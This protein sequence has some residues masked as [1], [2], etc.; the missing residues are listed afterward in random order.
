MVLETTR[1]I[2]WSVVQFLIQHNKHKGTMCFE[3]N[4]TALN[5]HWRFFKQK[6]VTVFSSDSVAMNDQGS[7]L[8][9]TLGGSV[10]LGS[11]GSSVHV[12]FFCF[13]FMN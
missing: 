1:I 10:A 6:K 7:S 9:C 4:K 8:L 11:L 2:L 3:E 12:L 5:K 13:C